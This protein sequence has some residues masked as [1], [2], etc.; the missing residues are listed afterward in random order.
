M[1]YDIVSTV[2]W[3][4]RTYRNPR[5][6]ASRYSVGSICVSAGVLDP[7]AVTSTGLRQSGESGC[8]RRRAAAVLQGGYTAAS[9]LRDAPMAGRAAVPRARESIFVV[10]LSGKKIP[11]KN[12]RT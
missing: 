7:A 10:V 2:G 12:A 3:T 8:G 11:I 6:Q 1:V 9:A 5:D 4:E